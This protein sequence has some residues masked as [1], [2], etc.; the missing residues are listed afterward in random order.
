MTPEEGAKL[1]VAS[2]LRGKDAVSGLSSDR[3]N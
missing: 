3:R 2:A 1:P